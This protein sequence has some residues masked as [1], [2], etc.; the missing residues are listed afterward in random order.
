MKGS[1][2]VAKFVP[3]SVRFEPIN[4]GVVLEVGDHLVTQMAADVDPRIR[5]ADP[6]ADLQSLREFLGSFDASSYDEVAGS[7]GTVAWLHEN[8]LPNVFF[9][10]PRAVDVD[11]ERIDEVMASLQARLVTRAFTRPTEITRAVGTS[12]TRTAL[13]EAF[14]SA[15]V[16]KRSVEVEV[17]LVGASGVEWR[18]DFRYLTP[19]DISLVQ[20]ATTGLQE[21]LRGKEHGFEAFLALLDTTRRPVAGKDQTRS[22]PTRGTLAVD[23]YPEENEI[24]SELSRLTSAHGLEFVAGQRGFFKLA[25]EVQR[26]ALPIDARNEAEEPNRTLWPS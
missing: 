18:I 25:Q 23:V 26:M 12:A 14:K 5:L 1:Y 13:R 10:A 22:A 11:V 7:T 17:P 8:G 4:I 19:T 20:T 9:S 2:S 15:G 16:L 3:D 6:Y 21:E 24:S